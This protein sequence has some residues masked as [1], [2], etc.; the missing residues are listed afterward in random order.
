M[1]KRR[2]NGKS[3]GEKSVVAISQGGRWE[4]KKLLM[5]C[6]EHLGG[7][8]SVV[9]RGD[10]VLLKPNLGYPEADGMPA[11]T[12]TTDYMVL[13]A[14]TE[15]FLE[16]GAKRVI[17]GDGPAHGITGEYMLENTG[18]KAAV[19]KVGGEVRGFD[20]EDYLLRKVPDGT[21]IHKQWLPRICLEA[22]VIVNVPKVKPTR[23]GK[24]TL[25]YKNWFG[26][27]PEDERMPWHRIPEH[28]YFLVD[29]FKVLPPTITV[30]DGLVIQEGLGPRFGTPVD[31]GVIIMG[32]DPVATETVTMLAIGHEPYE[33]MVIPIAAKAG[34]GTMDPAKIEVRGR[35]IESVKR[36]VKVS[37]GDYW[38]NPSPNVREYC[39]GTCWGCGLWVQYTPYPHE[40]DPKKKY[41]LLTGTTPKL[42]EKFDVD[43]VIV[44]GNCAID[45][46]KQIERVCARSGVKP[47]YISGCPPYPKRRP[48][49][50]KSHRI[51][52]LPYNHK[53]KRV[54]K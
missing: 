7:V 49:Y 35:D 18:I 11:W 34:Q 33:Q 54:A 51:E 27:V 29:L 6:F 31:W 20:E 45:H 47:Q 12:C 26:L 8:A 46:K 21:T 40:I 32:K 17:T 14:L 10:T 48:G 41:A 5:R 15:I 16:A 50:L 24:F 1:A 30:M 23:V 22:D 43:E 25:A 28:F 36:Y 53:V 2:T 37:P 52:H 39:G 13:A 44:L 3:A 38:L 19:E 42:P 9:K 4:A